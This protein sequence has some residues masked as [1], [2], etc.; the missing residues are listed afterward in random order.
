MIFT[1]S[2]IKQFLYCPR[3]IYF[4][5]VMPVD[6][7]PTFKMEFGKDEHLRAE[8]LEERR[9]LKIY[10]L[11]EGKRHFRL[12]LKSDRL[13]LSGI[14]DMLIISD[15][16]Y[17]PVDFKDST[18]PPGANHRYQLTAYSL[19]VEEK[20]GKPVRRGF[21]HLIP[22]KRT[23]AVDIT[24]SMRDYA[25]KII[26]RMARIVE[27]EIMPSANRSRSRCRDCEFRIWCGDV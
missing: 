22:V 1:V 6:K 5:Y 3:I 10:G 16:Q 18:R 14:L 4:T 21:I 7:K 23:Y 9:K 26:T 13:G 20:F 15:G 27:G 12:Y 11:E 2:D 25:K 8:G 17:Y 19:L 24:Q